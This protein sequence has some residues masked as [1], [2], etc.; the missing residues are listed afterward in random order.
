MWDEPYLIDIKDLLDKSWIDGAAVE[1][2][3]DLGD[4]VLSRKGHFSV[5]EDG[6]QDGLK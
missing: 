6:C 1:G 3:I 4:H 2:I 5:F